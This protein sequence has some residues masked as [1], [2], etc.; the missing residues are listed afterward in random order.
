MK[1]RVLIVVTIVISSGRSEKSFS[2]LMRI[3]LNQSRGS[4]L[5]LLDMLH[6]F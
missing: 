3:T 1:L 2:V 5:K 6:N 4:S